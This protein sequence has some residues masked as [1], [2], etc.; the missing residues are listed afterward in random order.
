MCIISE[1]QKKELIAYLDGLDQE[2]RE[3]QATRIKKAMLELEAMEI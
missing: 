1:E 3:D 2:I